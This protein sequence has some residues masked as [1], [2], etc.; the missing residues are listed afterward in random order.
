MDLEDGGTG[1][2]RLTKVHASNLAGID[3]MEFRLAG[4]L[5]ASPGA[6]LSK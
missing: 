5:A 6:S 2:I 1:P 4:E 3:H